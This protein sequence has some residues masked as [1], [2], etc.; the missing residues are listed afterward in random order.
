MLTD[1]DAKLKEH[2]PEYDAIVNVSGIGRRTQLEASMS[3]GYELFEEYEKVKRHMMMSSILTA[4]IAS[5][6]SSPDCYILFNSSLAAYDQLRV[7]KVHGKESPLEFV[8]NSTV[9]K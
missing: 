9:A 4:H 7:P 5:H 6:H 2:A 8:A 3:D 1:L